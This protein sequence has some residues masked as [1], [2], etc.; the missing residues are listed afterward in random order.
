MPNTTRAMSIDIYE[1][2]CGRHEL[3]HLLDEAM[4]AKEAGNFVD[5]DDFI[6]G[7]RNEMLE[8]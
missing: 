7:L 6:A 1:K 4:E 2:L 3:Y 5:Y 8:N